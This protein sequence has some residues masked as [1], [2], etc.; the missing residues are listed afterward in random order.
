MTLHPIKKKCIASSL[1]VYFLIEFIFCLMHQFLILSCQICSYWLNRTFW[2]M[3]ATWVYSPLAILPFNTKELC[4]FS[5]EEESLKT[6]SVIILGCWSIYTRLKILIILIIN[7]F[8]SLLC[9]T[10]MIETEMAFV[11]LCFAPIHCGTHTKMQHLRN[12]VL[13]CAHGWT[14]T[15][16]VWDEEG[17]NESPSFSGPTKINSM[18]LPIPLH[19]ASP[20]HRVYMYP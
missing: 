19:T 4:I 20:V 17:M 8:E 3:H 14:Y 16:T 12:N 10:R 13:T 5:G 9:R 2:Y 6:K 15:C 1:L 18:C 11:G 7:C